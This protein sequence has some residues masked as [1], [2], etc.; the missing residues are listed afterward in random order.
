MLQGFL[1]PIGESSIERK[2]SMSKEAAHHHAQA[3]EHHEH[4]ARHHREAAKHH[5]GGEHEKAAHHA[6]VATGTTPMPPTTLL[7]PPRPTP[8][9][10][11]QSRLFPQRA[12]RVDSGR[13]GRCCA[14]T[15]IISA[16][17]VW[18]HREFQFADA[19]ERQPQLRSLTA[20]LEAYRCCSYSWRPSPDGR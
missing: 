15:A 2:L 16:I 5:E 6:H 19:E 18:R 10:T 11:A 12:T 8:R 14:S 7:K 9:L 3:A 20:S 13:L 1:G 4:A 17:D